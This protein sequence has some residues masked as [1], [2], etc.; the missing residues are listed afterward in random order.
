MAPVEKAVNNT[1]SL[2]KKAKQELA[3]PFVYY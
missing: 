1:F 2:E 3:Y